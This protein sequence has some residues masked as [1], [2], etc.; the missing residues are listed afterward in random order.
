M[1]KSKTSN[2]IL[3]KTKELMRTNGE[4]TIKE[5][6]DAAYV[7]I[8][9]V[10][11]YFGSKENL[12]CNVLDEIIAELKEK[13][14]DAINNYNLEKMSLEKSILLIIDLIFSFTYENVGIV[15]YSFLQFG[16][17]DRSRNILVNEFLLD[18]EFT[19]LIIKKLSEVS[20]NT[21]INE[22]YAK[23]MLIFSAFSVPLFL[24]VLDQTY[25]KYTQLKNSDLKYHEFKNAYI[26]ELQKVLKS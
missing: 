7:N 4:V 6:A 12:I 21:N 22:L 5:I 17:Q 15:T 11:Y 3:E 18:E 2:L 24:G 25:E 14:V 20:S 8:A 13:I 9:A 23:Y 26:N 16:T 1:N 19:S 10:N